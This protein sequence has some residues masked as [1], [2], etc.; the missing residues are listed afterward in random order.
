LFFLIF[1]GVFVVCIGIA[2]TFALP[3]EKGDSSWRVG[4]GSVDDVSVW[5]AVV[6]GSF[7]YRL[8]FLVLK[9]YLKKYL[10]VWEKLLPLHSQSKKG[11]R[12]TRKGE[13]GRGKRGFFQKVL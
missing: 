3:I 7:V 4:S 6:C 8:R 9:K 10:V 13:I 1:F 2:F 11:V 5:F 12:E